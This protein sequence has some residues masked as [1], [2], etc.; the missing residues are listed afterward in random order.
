MTTNFETDFNPELDLKLERV[1]DVPR[2]LVWRAW[3]EPEH[4][5]V[6][7]CPRP[8]AV[9]ECEID[10][11]PG[12]KFNTTMRGPE[13]EVIPNS[14]CYLEVVPRERLVFTDCLAP[15]YRPAANPFMTAIVTM[16]DEGE[17][18]TRYVAIAKHGDADTRKK[19]EEMGFADGWST[20]LDQLVEYV[21]ALDK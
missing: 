7:F 3:T 4:L 2:D 16:S 12:G 10:L 18:K 19:H 1:V 11:R 17:G 8:W 9:S 15:G 6:W 14:G 5:K 13:G 21:K 20:A